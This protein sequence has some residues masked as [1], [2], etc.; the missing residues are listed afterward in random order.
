ME[1]FF[2]E[3]ALKPELYNLTCLSNFKPKYAV[4]EMANVTGHEVV[5]LPPYRCELI[6]I[7]LAWSQVK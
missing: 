3:Y 6:L 2:P 1:S 7:E 5:C 4:H